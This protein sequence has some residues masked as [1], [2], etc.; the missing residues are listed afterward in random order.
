MRPC[1]NVRA[2]YNAWRSSR[3][4]SYPDLDCRE[5]TTAGCGVDLGNGHATRI[6]YSACGNSDIDCLRLPLRCDDFAGRSIRFVTFPGVGE[7]VV[8]TSDRG[9][10]H[11]R[12]E[13]CSRSSVVHS[14][15]RINPQQ[16]ICSRY[17]EA[18]AEGDLAEIV[19][20]RVEDIIAHTSADVATVTGP[21]IVAVKIAE[22]LTAPGP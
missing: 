16:A 8:V 14:G 19:S 3:A 4:R 1:R 5:H 7:Y 2:P 12:G 15:E 6:A 17:S 10:W 13:R 22:V 21:Q 20:F 9:V 18:V 11:S